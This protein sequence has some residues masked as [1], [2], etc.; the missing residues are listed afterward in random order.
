MD[1]YIFH[2][3]QRF[4][5][6]RAFMDKAI[7]FGA[8]A[9]GTNAWPCGL[10]ET[11]LAA[12]AKSDPVKGKLIA[13]SPRP[14][15]FEMPM[16]ALNSWVTPNELFFVRSHL[17]TPNMDIKNWRLKVDGEVERPLDLSLDQLKQFEAIKLPALLECSGNGRS[18]YEPRVPGVQWGRGAVG[19][20]VWVGVRL[21]D[22]LKK[23]GIKPQGKHVLFDGAD[24]PMNAKVPD[25]VRSL[26]I[27]K[28][29]D[30]HTL[31]AYQMNGE[32]LPLSHGHPLRL[33]VPGWAGDHWVKWLIHIQVL[34]SEHDGHFMKNAYRFPT[35]AVKPGGE[36]DPKDMAVITGL[37][38]KSIIARPQDGSKTSIGSVRIMGAAWAG[39]ADIARVDVST[40]LGRTWHAA[41]L[42]GERAAYTWRL[43]EYHWKVDKPGSY[44]IM[45]RAT[46]SRKRV[47]PLSQSWNPSGYIWNVIDKVRIDVQAG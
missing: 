7:K 34:Q 43:W 13:H 10:F 46:D 2:P 12:Q 9:L 20:A 3:Q 19:N 32:P 33:I 42:G 14:E 1:S 31:L 18:F 24:K 41:Q 40:D 15:D 6:R 36:V 16:D 37:D 8:L 5:S 21:G 44:V 30:E 27:E 22:V 38:V 17:Y 39:E 11:S 28:A 47:Q 25:F 26:P 35:V 45:S 23:A 4:V 29:L